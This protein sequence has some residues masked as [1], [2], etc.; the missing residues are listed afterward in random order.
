MSKRIVES[1]QALKASLQLQAIPRLAEPSDMAQAISFLLGEQSQMITGQII[2]I[3][4][5][6]SATKRMSP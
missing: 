4:G 3:D 5:G 1:E 6:L 2:A